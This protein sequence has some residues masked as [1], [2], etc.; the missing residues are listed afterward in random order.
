MKRVLVVHASPR[1]DGNSS[2]LAQSFARGAEEAGN[3]VRIIEVGHADIA[4]CKACEF[5]FSHEGSCCQ[6]DDMQRFYPLLRECDVLVFATPMYFLQLPRAVGRF[7]IA[8]SAASPSRS[9]SP[10]VGLLLCFED[11]GRVHGASSRRFVSRVRRILQA[12]LDRRGFG[13]GCLRKGAI[14]GNPGLERAY[15]LGKSIR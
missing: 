14:A 11:K 10:E 12:D 8:C 15:E 9:A 4:G 1:S 3:A 6:Q 7:R 2:M 5:C 13:A